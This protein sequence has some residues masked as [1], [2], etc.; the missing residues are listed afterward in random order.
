MLF[1]IVLTSL[2]LP[3]M[4]VATPT[5]IVPPQGSATFHFTTAVQTPKGTHSGSGDVTVQR[6]GTR[7]ATLTIRSDDGKPPRTVPLIVGVDGSVAPDPSTGDSPPADPEAKAQ[8]QAFM[9]EMTVAARVEIGALKGSGDSLYTVPI[10]LAP[11]GKGTPVAT[12]LTM[13]GSPAEYTGRT[14]AATTT[15]LPKGGSLDP[16]EIAK[17][18]GVSAAAYEALT[19]AGRVTTAAVMHRKHQEEKQAAGGMLPDTMEMTV[20]LAMADGRVG[21]IRGAQTDT[22]ALPNSPVRIETTWTFTKVPS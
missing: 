21:E 8:A 15:Q 20:T 22:V 11:V 9:A 19:P 18:I 6:T 17:T 2:T 13:T 10:T 3:M 12:Q 4:A 14:T 16:H 7:A 5:G 1:R